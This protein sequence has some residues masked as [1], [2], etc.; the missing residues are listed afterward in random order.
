MYQVKEFGPE[1]ADKVIFMF[2]GLGVRYWQLNL[3][4]LPLWSFRRSGWRVVFYQYSWD[5]MSSVETYMGTLKAVYADAEQRLKVLP[6]DTRVAVFGLSWGSLAATRLA[7]SF[8][9]VEALILNVPYSD[10]IVHLYD[11]KP[12]RRIPAPAKYTKKFLGSTEAGA[13]FGKAIAA[14]APYHRAK[15]M[16]HLRVMLFFAHKDKFFLPKYMR[17]LCTA[18]Q[19]HAKEFEFSESE[20]FGHTLGASK[21]NFQSGKWLRW[22]D[23]HPSS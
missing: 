8:K 19:K 7:A 5:V 10:P 2:S 1:D 21:Y 20:N 13:S 3:P 22:L 16:G 11:F 9:R 12:T 17:K 6:T 4:G 18:L 23:R 15:D 14:Y